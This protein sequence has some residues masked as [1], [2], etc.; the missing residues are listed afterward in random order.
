MSDASSRSHTE[1]A[2]QGRGAPEVKPPAAGKSSEGSELVLPRL[3]CFPHSDAA[4]QLWAARL[5]AESSERYGAPVTPGRLE[6]ALR[7]TFPLALVRPREELAS[8]RSEAAW[9]V[10]RD[11]R[12]SPF[13]ND[14]WWEERDVMWLDTGPD[15][16]YLD[17]S[18]S[19]VVLS[20]HARERL[21][22]MRT[23]ELADPAVRRMVPW[24]WELLE[25][26]GVLHSTSIMRAADGRRVPLE[27]RLVKDGGGP[28]RARSY[29]RVVPIEAARPSRSSELPP[30][31][32]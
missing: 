5:L 6:D 19:F 10:Y 24:T 25:A 32:S 2:G 8:L 18:D 30:D 31:R 17:A 15:G 16:R 23:G 28:G 14:P 26:T 13:S 9:Y 21:T 11:G 1:P 27:Y 12:Y 29:M 7:R 3:F 4:F 22:G 20:G